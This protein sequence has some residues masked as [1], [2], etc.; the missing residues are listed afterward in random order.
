ME[1]AINIAKYL[2][3]LDEKREDFTGTLFEYNGRRSYEGNIRLNKYLHIMQMVYIAKTGKKLFDDVLYA[4]DNG[5]I[6]NEVM[7]NYKYICNHPVN[8][9]ITDDKIRLFVDKMYRILR[10]APT[11]A[12]ISISHRDNEWKRKHGF[13]E[14][15]QQIMN[16]D[17]ETEAYKAMFE[18]FLSVLDND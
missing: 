14:K 17:N 18:D 13:Y 5:A 1:K 10:H 3:S 15:Q 16:I 7:E 12:L 8:Y 9:Q 6:V 2:L 4:F 11:E